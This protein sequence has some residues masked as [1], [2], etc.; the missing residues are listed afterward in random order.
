MPR[1]GIMDL[2]TTAE[3]WSRYWRGGSVNSCAGDFPENYTGTIADFWNR[4]FESV[5]DNALIADLGTGNGAVLLLASEFAR[6]HGLQFNLHGI[7]ASDTDPSVAADAGGV[8][9]GI[10]FHVRTSITE[11]PFAD[12]SV[13]LVCSQF[14]IEYADWSRAVAEVA[15][16]L[17]ASGSLAFVMHSTDSRVHE[18]T[19]DQLD[20]FESLNSS[21]LLGYARTM[22]PLLAHAKTD[23]GREFLLSSTDA[24]TTRIAINNASRQIVER[25]EQSLVPATLAR[26]LERV[27]AVLR[28]AQEG[29][30]KLATDALNA[31][32][33]DLRD[34]SYRH[35]H[36]H[37]VA[38]APGALDDA[39]TTLKE[40]GFVDVSLAPIDQPSGVR[41]GW[42]LTARRES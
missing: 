3:V 20:N 14:G 26:T 9:R 6:C 12:R 19:I 24:E 30:P 35:A 37:Q 2:K 13:A 40:L 25:I 10:R 15:R 16:V 21:G 11:L 29:K 4:Q 28:F 31:L 38:L 39:T 23:A 8:Y 34:E 7:D 32:E 22:I 36:L 17:N 27:I 33:S 1:H 42:S 5:G 18:S 41:Y